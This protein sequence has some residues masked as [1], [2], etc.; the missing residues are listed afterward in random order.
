M[1]Q[2]EAGHL[3]PGRLQVL[4]HGVSGNLCSLPAEPSWSIRDV[5]EARCSSVSV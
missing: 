4:V 2:L 1:A 3:A 5:R